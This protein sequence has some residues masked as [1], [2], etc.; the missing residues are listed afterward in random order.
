MT[1]KKISSQDANRLM[2]DAADA[3]RKLAAERDV[4]KTKCAELEAHQ[5]AEKLASRMH[6]RG[7]HADVSHEALVERLEKMA[8]TPDYSVMEKA[9]DMVG[10]NLA[11]GFKLAELSDGGD[12]PATGTSALERWVLGTTLS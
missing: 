10:P 8:G 12:G 4:Y 1:M 7:I 3:L 9:V 11:A 5:A 2:L 6:E